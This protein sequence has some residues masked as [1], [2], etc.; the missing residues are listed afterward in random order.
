MKK[1]EELQREIMQLIIIIADKKNSEAV[2]KIEN[3]RLELHDALDFAESD[4]ELVRIGKF[5]KIVEEL[6]GKL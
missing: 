6:E 1:L 4:E 5:L 3:I 2:A